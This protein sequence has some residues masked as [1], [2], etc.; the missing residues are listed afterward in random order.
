[1]L[2]RSVFGLDSDFT[3]VNIKKGSF[4]FLANQDRDVAARFKFEFMLK[5]HQQATL[6]LLRVERCKKS[7]RDAVLQKPTLAPQYP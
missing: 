6:L 4:T 7:H 3:V 1:M 5:R 2:N